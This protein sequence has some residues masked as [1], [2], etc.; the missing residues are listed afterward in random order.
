MTRNVS[1]SY[2]DSYGLAR[3]SYKFLGVGQDSPLVTS[4]TIWPTVL[5]QADGQMKPKYREKT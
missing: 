1:F 5:G 3:S 2:R 4:V